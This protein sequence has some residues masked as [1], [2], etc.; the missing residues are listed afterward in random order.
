MRPKPKAIPSVQVYILNSI[1]SWCVV[2]KNSSHGLLLMTMYKC[3]Q[4]DQGEN[5]VVRVVSGSRPKLFCIESLKLL[6]M[7]TIAHGCNQSLG[8][9][10]QVVRSCLKNS[11][12]NGSLYL[13]ALWLNVLAVPLSPNSEHPQ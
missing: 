9:L 1:S 2:L 4:Q 6:Q 12:F 5:S 7:H 8:K 3:V 10:R 13:L 11:L